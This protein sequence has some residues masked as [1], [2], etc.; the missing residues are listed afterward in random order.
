MLVEARWAKYITI[1]A[2]TGLTPRV[3]RWQSTIN[4]RHHTFIAGQ[5]GFLLPG[6]LDA[7][8]IGV[9]GTNGSIAELL[10]EP[11]FLPYMT[12]SSSIGDEKFRFHK[13][14]ISQQRCQIFHKDSWKIHIQK[15]NGL[16]VKQS[17]KKN[18]IKNRTDKSSYN[19]DFFRISQLLL[20]DTKTIQ[21][22]KHFEIP[23]KRVRNEVFEWQRG[24]K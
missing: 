11:T 23:R 17:P 4:P 8:R 3:C 20:L 13:A 16:I 15:G 24:Y 12:A 7:I 9:S 14:T 22:E 6:Q 5:Y 21:S 10:A 19:I 1:P 2:K 18:Y